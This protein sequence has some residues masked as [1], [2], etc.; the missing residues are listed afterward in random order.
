MFFPLITHTLINH[1]SEI[2]IDLSGGNVI[3]RKWENI[4]KGRSIEIAGTFL[5]TMGY[6]QQKGYSSCFKYNN[7]RKVPF[8]YDDKKYFIGP[9]PPGFALVKIPTDETIPEEEKQTFRSILQ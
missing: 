5:C 6:R 3:L 1:G 4:I 7:G 9:E 2:L 8:Y